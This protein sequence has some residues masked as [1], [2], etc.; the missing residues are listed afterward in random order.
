MSKRK[1]R[2]PSARALPRK[3]VYLAA[4]CILWMVT[5]ALAAFAVVEWAAPFWGI[6]KR[7]AIF[8]GGVFAVS[9]MVT[10]VVTGMLAQARAWAFAGLLFV[11]GAFGAVDSAGWT[12]AAWRL[13]SRVAASDAGY[14]AAL[15]AW[16]AEETRLQGDVTA[17]RQRLHGLPSILTACQGLGPAGCATRREGLAE[18]R[19]SIEAELET[20]SNALAA[21][22]KQTPAPDLPD[23]FDN[24]LIGIVGTFLQIALAI[25]F[26]GIEATALRRHKE[27]LAEHAAAEEANRKQKLEDQARKAADAARLAAAREKGEGRKPARKPP[28]PTKPR[29]VYSSSNDN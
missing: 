3:P 10:P 4:R 5:A 27:A 9:A 22:Y 21:F 11:C 7:L 23:L 16:K 20:A 14:T 15:S 28:P 19:V 8:T 6:D 1:R 26:W 13:E 12:V 29:L 2:S 17:A 25:A 18:E 24:T